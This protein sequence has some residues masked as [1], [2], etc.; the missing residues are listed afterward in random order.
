MQQETT[1]RLWRLC[2]KELRE[3]L[4]DRRTI[5]TLV[6]MPLLLYP[7]LG[8]TLQRFLLTANAEVNPVFLIGAATEREGAFLRTLIEDPR[9]MPPREIREASDSELAAF[10][11]VGHEDMSPDEA[12][13]KGLINIACRVVEWNP[14]AI[15]LTSIIGDNAS[16]DARRI[17]V[18]R[19][20]W[21]KMADAEARISE[22]NSKPYEAPWTIRIRNIGAEDKQSLL[23]TV[24]PLV[25]IL[26]TI[27]GAVYPAIDLTAGERERGTIEALIASP[28]SRSQVLLAKYVAVVTVAL[29]TALVN[30]L[31]MFMTLWATGLLSQLTVGGGFP[32][33]ELFQIFVLL[34]LFSGFFSAVLLSLT[35]FAKSFKEAQAYLIPLMLLA[36]TPGIFS[37]MPGVQ[38]T[39]A[40]AVVPLVNIV[41]LAR[42]LLSGGIAPVP[43]IAAVLSTFA[44]AAAALGIAARL[45]GSDAVL[46]GSELSIGSIFQR[47]DVPRRVP[48]INAAS[49]MLAVLFPIYF[50][51]SN[52]IARLSPEAI[53]AR[54][55]LNSASLAIVFGGVPLLAAILGRNRFATTFRLDVPQSS[56]Q[57]I[58]SLAGAVLMG[59]GLWALAH[60]VFVI[61]DW[62][63]MGGLEMAKLRGAQTVLDLLRS[64]PTWLVLFALAVT[65]AVIEELCFRGYLFSSLSTAMS[66]WRVIVVSSL[67]FGLFHVLTGSVLLIERLFPTTMMGLFLG[68]V[69]WK[70]GSIYPG[71]LLH[72]V[73]N[74]FLNLVAI[75]KDK[76]AF[77]GVAE[78]E[79]S[80]LPFTW[81]VLATTI[82]MVGVAIIWLCTKP[83]EVAIETPG[84]PFAN[85]PLPT[86]TGDHAS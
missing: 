5:L 1:G 67:L 21:M 32:G 68:W 51:V 40:L 80:H 35:S 18:E 13:E 49:L 16:L 62:L 37:L 55:L 50:V 10:D 45:F 46:R 53:E 26:M 52:V 4:R 54:L 31:A 17:L 75:Y 23:A 7:L 11:V 15:E 36:L 65:P 74:G 25:L 86:S 47:P 70:T 81:I 9:S 59:V 76:L 24:I 38:L 44:Y 27:T 6:L 60:E 33:M 58:G 61:A 39:P 20:Q 19:L 22:L 85:Q 29:L 42:D 64:A 57:L 43:A 34:I 41:L 73:H 78:D 3:T 84:T 71:M 8:M 63:G 77:L 2:R 12:L 83:R 30:L 72:A 69:A 28:I 82:A 79:A 48:S 66:P 14:P 56:A